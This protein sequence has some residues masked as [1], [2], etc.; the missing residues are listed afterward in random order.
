M[1][2][3]C[4]GRNYVE[5]AREL[6]NE[7]PAEPVVFMKPSTALV[8]SNKPVFYPD[9][10]HDLHYEGE[11]VLRISRNGK[12]IQTRFAHKYFDAVTVGFDLT[13]RDLQSELKAKGL[14]WEVAKGFDQSAPVGRFLPVEAA[15]T[16]GEFHYSVLLNGNLVQQGDTS[17]MIYRIERLISHIST[18]FTLQK[19]DLI[20]TGTPSGVGPLK[21]GDELAGLVGREEV[22]RFAVK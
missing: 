15:M 21:P 4:I 8:R 10:T 13:A 11:L 22:I 7:V 14:P 18:F 9:F 20:F 6:G 16:G 19:G 1:K 17:L 3:F 5:H 2:I 12:R